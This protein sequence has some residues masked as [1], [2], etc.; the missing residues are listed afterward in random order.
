MPG[1]IL[2]NADAGGRFQSEPLAPGLYTIQA[3]PECTPFGC[4]APKEV[5][6]S[7]SNEY[8]EISTLSF[9]QL[10]S[11][12]NPWQCSTDE[13]DPENGIDLSVTYIERFPKYRRLHVKQQHCGH[14]DPIP[15]PYPFCL[16]VPVRPTNFLYESEI[17]PVGECDGLTYAPPQHPAPLGKRAPDPGE[18]VTYMAH[19]KNK[20][21]QPSQSFT[22]AWRLN[23]EPIGPTG[24]HPG[25]Q[26]DPL[27]PET[28]IE[29]V[30]SLELLGT[31]RL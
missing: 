2:I 9:I 10:Q 28:S 31:R 26:P 27:Y 11:A 17:L 15:F 19:V 29:A 4:R 1:D 21:T 12:S 30:F 25:L 16:D 13:S 14:N 6:I 18:A 7:W 20:G 22:Y 5:T 23:G 8:V 3:L 24:T